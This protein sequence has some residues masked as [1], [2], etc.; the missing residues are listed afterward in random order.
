MNKEDKIKTNVVI[1]NTHHERGYGNKE[2]VM[3]IE[4]DNGDKHILDLE[5]NADISK[6]DYLDIVDTKKTKE[7]VLFKNIMFDTEKLEKLAKGGK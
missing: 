2:G 1:V 5:S 3:I 7:N 4:K 6:S